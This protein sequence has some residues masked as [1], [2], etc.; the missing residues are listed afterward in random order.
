[1]SAFERSTLVLVVSTPDS[2]T[3][4]AVFVFVCANMVYCACVL[5]CFRPFEA[6]SFVQLYAQRTDNSFVASR[7][8]SWAWH[9]CRGFEV[10]R[11]FAG[12][13]HSLFQ[14]IFP[15]SYVGCINMHI[16]NRH[17]V[18]WEV[19]RA[20]SVVHILSVW[21]PRLAALNR[22]I[23]RFPRLFQGSFPLSR[24]VS[25]VPPDWP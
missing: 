20:Y 4:H 24:C 6:V 8:A 15:C 1:M 18:L 14:Q 11:S 13:R 3:P 12:R 2:T 5:G 16:E 22:S 7:M 9:G 23:R 25:R 10:P 19:V 21:R 17:I